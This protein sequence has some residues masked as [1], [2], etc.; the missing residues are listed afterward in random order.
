MPIYVGTDANDRLTGSNGSDSIAGLDGDD[1]IDD[2]GAGAADELVG[3]RGND[4][5]VVRNPG[6]TIV[7]LPGE[8]FDEVRTALPV[9]RLPANVEILTYTGFFAINGVGNDG[10][11]GF[12]GGTGADTFVGLDGIDQFLAGSGAANTLI[13]GPGDDTYQNEALGDTIIELPGEGFDTVFTR[14]LTF[15]LPANVEV[16][17]YVNNDSQSFAGIGNSENNTISGA[18]GADTLIGYGG[19]DTLEGGTGAANTLIGGPGDDVYQSNAVGD[20]IIELAGEG[21]DTISTSLVSFTMPANTERLNYNGTANFTGVGNASNNIIV[22]G[23]GG[24]VL[25]GLGGND[26]LLSSIGLAADTAANTLIGGAGDDE[27]GLYNPGDTVI[28]LNGEGVDSV[29]VAYFNAYTLPA[30]VENLSFTGGTSGGVSGTGNALDN[31]IFGSFGDDVLSGL[32]G[33]DFIVGGFGDDLIFGGLGSDTINVSAG[34]DTIFFGAGESGIDL[35]QAFTTGQDRLAFSRAA[36]G[37]TATVDFVSAF[38]ST[39][40]PTSTNSTFLYQRETNTLSFDVD[41]TG[42]AAAIILARFE[43]SSVEANAFVFY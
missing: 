33:D 1:T 19:N 8:G 15:V 6:H 4:I 16:V 30:N 13:G 2:G 22:G 25:I 32:A 9:Y 18:F 7:E 17:R 27:Y 29:T 26:R 23:S 35:I 37:L 39:A 21:F 43:N 24:D 5:Y 20:T 34:S 41:G 28:E 42:P 14:Q 36:F 11:N 12:I 38:G 31:R 10:N 3:G 40:V